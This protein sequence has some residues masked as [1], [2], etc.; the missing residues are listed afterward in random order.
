[1]KGGPALILVEDKAKELYLKNLMLRKT[2][3]IT[4]Y[5]PDYL[6]NERLALKLTR[7]IKE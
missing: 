4:T 6:Y 7:N 2:E 3:G 5:Q 1:M